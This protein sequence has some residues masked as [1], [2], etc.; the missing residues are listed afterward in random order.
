MKPVLFSSPSFDCARACKELSK[1]DPKL[2]KL[3][4]KVGPFELKT[5]RQFSPFEYLV[6]SIVFQQ[7]NGKAAGTIHSRLLDVFGG[8]QPTP[9]ELMKADEKLLAAAGISRNKMLAL[10]DLAKAAHEGRVPERK[11]MLKM[12]D[13]EIIA[14]LDPIRGIGRWTVEML[15]IFGLGRADVLALDDFALKKSAMILHGKK[16]LTRAEFQK[17]GERWAPY[18]SI[19]SWYLWRALD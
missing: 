12:H 17:L 2:G 9:I 7:L 10:K 3:I 16:S 6:R 1:L 18:R 14:T 11:A 19:A 15:L 5:R 13:E 8:R 4:K